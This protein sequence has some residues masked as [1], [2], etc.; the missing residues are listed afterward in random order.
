MIWQMWLRLINCKIFADDAKIYAATLDRQSLQTDLLSLLDWS[1]SWQLKFNLSKCSVM[2]IG[3]GNPYHSYYLDSNQSE[4]LSVVTSEKDL[5]VLFDGSMNFDLHIYGCI[6]RSNR[7]IGIIYRSFDF[8]DIGTF[9]IMYKTVI[10]PI[11]EY[12]NVVWSPI[13]KRQSVALEKVQRRA[14]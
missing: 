6:N 5:G 9:I 14:T 8:L 1:N 4:S 13:F 12:G 10:R 2:H 11:L 3:K 7:L